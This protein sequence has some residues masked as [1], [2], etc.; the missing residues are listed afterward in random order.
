MLIAA[1]KP[2]LCPIHTVVI[3]LLFF[4][5]QAC[6]AATR[7]SWSNRSRRLTCTSSAPRGCGTVTST[8]PPVSLVSTSRSFL[9]VY[10]STP[11]LSGATQAP[12]RRVNINFLC[13]S[14]SHFRDEFGPPFFARFHHCRHHSA[15]PRGLRRAARCF[16]L[17]GVLSDLLCVRIGAHFR[18]GPVQTAI[19]QGC[20]AAFKANDIPR[21]LAIIKTGSPTKTAII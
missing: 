15:V 12:T 21:L 10:S 16:V 8:C 13:F 9:A 6:A 17:I 1:C 14:F 19:I 18:A 2:M 5:R 4:H 11:V 3:L 7:P 20:R